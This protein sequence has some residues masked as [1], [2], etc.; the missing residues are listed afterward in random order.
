MKKKIIFAAVLTAMAFTACTNNDSSSK[1]SAESPVNTTASENNSKSAETEKP[2]DDTDAATASGSESQIEVQEE[3]TKSEAAEFQEKF[4]SDSFNELRN[5]LDG[6]R[7]EIVPD[8]DDET[9]LAAV[10]QSANLLFWAR[11][12]TLMD[13]EIKEYWSE[14]TSGWEPEDFKSFGTNFALVYDECS[15]VVDGSDNEILSQA[16]FSENDFAGLEL[17]LEPIEAI[18][19]VAE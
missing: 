6:I 12:T 2:S 16:G 5:V 15:A 8:Q 18:K 17:P 4:K 1:N 19:N 13:E 10:K 3:T 9:K 7:T 11:G 14:Y